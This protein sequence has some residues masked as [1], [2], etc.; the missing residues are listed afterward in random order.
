MKP[1][2]LNLMAARLSVDPV[3]LLDTLKATVFQKA[4]NEEL[5]A[6]VVV[7]NEYGLNPL[8]REIFAFP[9]KS[10][11][12]VPM[13][14]IDGWTKIVNRQE[15]YDG[16]EFAWE[17]DDEK[18]PV[19]CTCTIYVKGRSKPVVATEFFEECFRNTEPWKGMPRRMLRHKAFMQTA[20]LAFGFSGI[21]DP[22][23]AKD[24]IEVGST[25]MP[26]EPLKAI[27]APAGEAKAEAAAGL[28]PAEKKSPQAELESLCVTNGHTFDSLQKWGLESG[29]IE[30]ADSMAG[31]ADVPNDVCKRL[32]RAQDG[33]LKGLEQVKKP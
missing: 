2:A 24:I 17:F 4:T 13:V 23:E 21:Y 8:L 3:K 15:N 19:S 22:D 7:S 16:L 14:P 11:G 25:V 5:L 26:A 28:A 18:K 30:G 10:G 12:I 27:G 1:S 33:L 9:G 29:N 32:L 31:F 6:L 20:R